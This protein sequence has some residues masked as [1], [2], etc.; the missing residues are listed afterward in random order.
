LAGSLFGAGS[1]TTAS[2]MSVSV[3]AA[4]CYPE[5]AEK[6]REELD[7]VIGKER[8]AFLVGGPWWSLNLIFCVDSA[9][10]E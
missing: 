5:A 4:A 6:V 2:V 8:R 9:G 1:D 10:V 7:A 3:M